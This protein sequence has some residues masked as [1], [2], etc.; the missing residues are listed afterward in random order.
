MQ[1]GCGVDQCER[2]AVGFAIVGVL[3]DERADNGVLEWLVGGTLRLRQVGFEVGWLPEE[4]M[5]RACAI[6]RW[7]GTVGVF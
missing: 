4:G 1:G 5:T 3:L 7:P 2:G 6:L